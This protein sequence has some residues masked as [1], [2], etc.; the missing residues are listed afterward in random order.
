MQPY[1]LSPVSKLPTLPPDPSN[2]ESALNVQRNPFYANLNSPRGRKSAG[3]GMGFGWLAAPMNYNWESR[4]EKSCSG[5]SSRSEIGVASEEVGRPDGG[6]WEKR[7]CSGLVTRLDAAV[8]CDTHPTSLLASC[9]HFLRSSMSAVSSA[10]GQTWQRK[11]VSLWECRA[12]SSIVFHASK[13]RACSAT[14]FR[15]SFLSRD[16]HGRWFVEGMGLERCFRVGVIF[17]RCGLR[18]VDVRGRGKSLWFSFFFGKWLFARVRRCL[19]RYF[20]DSFSKRGSRKLWELCDCEML[21]WKIIGFESFCE[22]F[23][24]GEDD[25]WMQRRC[26]EKY[27]RDLFLNIDWKLRLW[28]FEGIE[29]PCAVFLKDDLWGM[30]NED[31][32]KSFLFFRSED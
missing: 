7:R 10:V 30:R 3:V 6:G 13:V 5:G 11:K 12:S 26:P 27:F 8:A 23:W 9:H 14:S 25:S 28:I 2:V 31:M 21:R 1:L 18:F 24:G 32:L 4:V 22:F 19:E 29:N 17:S 16:S 20:R 15:K